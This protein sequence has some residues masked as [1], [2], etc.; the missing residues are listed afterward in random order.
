MNCLRRLIRIAK[1]L[2]RR[3]HRF[4]PSPTIREKVCLYTLNC[5]AL[6]VALSP[7]GAHEKSGLSFSPPCESR[8]KRNRKAAL[9]AIEKG[10]GKDVG[11]KN[12]HV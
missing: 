8:L 4:I 9:D 5:D 3:A 2:P 6:A 11:D 10:W 7:D 1:F 12:K